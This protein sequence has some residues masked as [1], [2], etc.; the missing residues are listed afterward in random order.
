MALSDMEVGS[1]WQ[2]QRLN[3][4]RN[5]SHSTKAHS[6]Q[7]LGEE[8]RELTRRRREKEERDAKKDDDLSDLGW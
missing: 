2:E 4:W 7:D 6:A 5:R 1:N 3:Q 8:N